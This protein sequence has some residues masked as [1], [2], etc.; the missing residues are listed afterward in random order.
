MTM[1]VFVDFGLFELVGAA[2]LLFVSRWI[3]RNRVTAFSFLAVA[4]GG[5]GALVVMSTDGLGRW[6][7]VL[8][9]TSAVICVSVLGTV[10]V[11]APGLLDEVASGLLNQVTSSMPRFLRRFRRA[12]R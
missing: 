5:P 10:L 9:L 8:S 3:F 11:K 12:N 7:A 1:E 4:V 2:A 6:L